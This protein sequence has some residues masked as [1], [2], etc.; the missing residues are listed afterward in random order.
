VYYRKI[1]S[2]LETGE[3]FRKPKCNQLPL[4]DSFKVKTQFVSSAGDEVQRSGNWQ[5]CKNSPE[6]SWAR[7]SQIGDSISFSFEGNILAVEHGLHADSNM[8]EIIIDGK[9]EDTVHPV[10]KEI[11]TNQLVIGYI[12]FSLSDGRHNVEIKTVEC[13][14]EG[15]QGSQVHI[16]NF[17]TGNII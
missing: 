10:Y 3:Y 15:V 17:I 11:R 4:T 1:I 6:R 13:T 9:K 14:K 8:Y 16:Y 7:S 5:L 2:C 12:N